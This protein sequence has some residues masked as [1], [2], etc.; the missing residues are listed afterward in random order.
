MLDD[1]AQAVG[2][3]RPREIE[4]VERTEARAN[5]KRRLFKGPLGITICCGATLLLLAATSI[6]GLSLGAMASGALTVA[7]VLAC[8]VGMYFMMRTMNKK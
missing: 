1:N 8:P 4:T 2:L 6:F 3:P 7:A 5:R